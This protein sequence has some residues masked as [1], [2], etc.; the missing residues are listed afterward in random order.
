MSDVLDITTEAVSD[1]VVMHMKNASGEPMYADAARTKPRRIHFYGPGS[2]AYAAM[3]ARQ[4]ARITKRMAENEGKYVAPTAEDA[5]K[6]TA[7][8]YASITIEFENFTYPPAGDARGATLFAAFYADR[9]LGFVLK[10]AKAFLAD[11][12][13]SKAAS[14]GS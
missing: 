9:K 10:Q 12:G 13:N 4:N 14:S 3:E 2:A 1:T 6:E 11:W 5:A 7:E 8:D